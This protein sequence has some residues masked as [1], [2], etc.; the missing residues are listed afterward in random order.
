MP[1]LSE[2]REAGRPPKELK[3]QNPIQ[4]KDIERHEVSGHPSENFPWL[5]KNEYFQWR[6]EYI[7]IIAPNVEHSLSED[8]QFKYRGHKDVTRAVAKL[9]P[10]A[11]FIG[12]Y[13]HKSSP[14]KT[15][16]ITIWNSSLYTNRDIGAETWPIFYLE[17]KEL[18]D[19][20]HVNPEDIGSLRLKETQIHFN[21]NGLGDKVSEISTSMKTLKQ[22]GEPKE[23]AEKWL[24]HSIEWE[25]MAQEALMVEEMA[26]AFYIAK[27]AHNPEN[28]K[29]FINEM[30][31]YIGADPNINTPLTP[32]EMQSKMS[33][34][35]NKMEPNGSIPSCRDIILI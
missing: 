21:V 8:S 24:S 19:I 12:D 33:S 23:K 26:H 7:A 32:E 6:D 20:T 22:G 2:N 17:E 9:F 1:K 35:L 25:G 34:Q 3:S 14:D 27:A 29:M 30:K 18:R 4:L 31:T 28:L 5:P 10:R 15:T 16:P 11:L 13:L